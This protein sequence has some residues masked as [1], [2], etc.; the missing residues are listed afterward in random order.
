MFPTLTLNPNNYNRW[1]ENLLR[2]AEANDKIPV[3]VVRFSK[4]GNEPIYTRRLYMYDMFLFMNL[5]LYDSEEGYLFNEGTPGEYLRASIQE[6]REEHPT[7][8]DDDM[9]DIHS[10]SRN[11]WQT[12]CLDH[13]RGLKIMARQIQLSLSHASRRFIHAHHADAAIASRTTFKMFNIIRDSHPV[14]MGA[15]AS[16]LD[17]SMANRTVEDIRQGRRPLDECRQAFLDVA[18]WESAKARL[19]E[20]AAIYHFIA[21]VTNP[22][23]KPSEI[24][25]SPSTA[26]LNSPSVSPALLGSHQG[27]H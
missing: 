12:L 4:N 7:P 26:R 27:P 5:H 18:T 1:I 2:I 9:F 6:W 16:V 10:H 23:G 8:E 14:T 11:H 25:L 19:S 21:G 13:D 3:S 17:M 22:H 15:R 20:S 24:F